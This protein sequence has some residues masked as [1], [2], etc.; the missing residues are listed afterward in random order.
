MTELSCF[1]EQKSLVLTMC[2]SH[3]VE[4]KANTAG[5]LLGGWAAP[6]TNATMHAHVAV[7]LASLT[8]L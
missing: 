1:L 2:S 3:D 4:R 8:T 6:A 5:S 7:L